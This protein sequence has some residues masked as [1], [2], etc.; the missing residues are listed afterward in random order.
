VSSSPVEVRRVTAGDQ[1]EWTR[2]FRGYRVFYE[3]A[4]DADAIEVAWRWV[5]GEQHGL[6][7]LVAHRPGSSG[8]LGLANVRSFARPSS[9]TLGLF[10]DDL[11][12]DPAERRSGVGDA[13]LRACGALA[14]QRG[15][16]VV[17][18]TTSQTNTR[19]RALYDSYAEATRWVTYDMPPG[20]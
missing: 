6:T 19:A 4:D 11:F 18:W 16:S 2:L 3:L 10:L 13:L 7:G 20:A 14:A 9:A 15:A 5:V 17:R 1:Q 8:L 12:T